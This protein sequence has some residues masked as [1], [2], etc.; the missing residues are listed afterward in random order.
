MEGKLSVYVG[1][2]TDPIRFGTG[3]VF[4]GKGEGLYLFGLER[5]S[6]AAA[7]LVWKKTG[8]TNPSFLDLSPSRR[9]LYAVNELKDYEGAKTGTLSAFALDAGGG[10]PRF[11]NRKP[12]F[13]TDP[14]HVAVD[15]S[16]RYA[17]VANYSSGSV[18][19]FPLL[20][21]GSLGDASDFKA[22]RGSSVDPSRQG[23]PH[24]H[25]A[26]FDRGGARL[27]VSD[28]GTDELVVYG[29]DSDHGKLERRDE[30]CFKARPGAG[31]RLLAPHPTSPIAYLV[32]EL[33][34][35][36]SVLVRDTDRSSFRELQ[37][38][39]T[40]PSDYAGTNS[41]ADLHVSPSGDFLYASNR[42]HDS[43]AGFRIDPGTGGLESIGH[44]PSG[45]RTPRSF[46]IDPSG[47]FLFAANQDSDNIVV[48]RI[49][50]NDGTLQATGGEIRVP[51][52]VCVRVYDSVAKN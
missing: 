22:H 23:G 46:A 43:I 25:S 32:N 49:D 16:G 26:V 4:K 28:L 14:C 3:Q 29:W 33:D 38:I 48:F 27:F 15:P 31:P 9:F 13:G 1:T 52:P 35:T 47:R 45:G 24:A 19:V 37:A 39:G 50:P 20:P 51:T 18:C 12:T 42:G 44:F 2:Y 34:S 40:L 6:G 30:L 8:V 41:C 21:D 36:V 7:R 17:V 10:E 11:L 5:E